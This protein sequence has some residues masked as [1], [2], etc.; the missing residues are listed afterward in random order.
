M[1]NLSEYI[2]ELEVQAT[3]SQ[4]AKDQLEALRYIVVRDFSDFIGKIDT[5]DMGNQL[6]KVLRSTKDTD[7]VPMEEATHVATVRYKRKGDRKASRFKVYG[8]SYPDAVARANRAL[9]NG[10]F[11]EGNPRCTVEGKTVTLE[12]V[13]KKAIY[14][15]TNTRVQKEKA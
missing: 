5:E 11:R 4:R 14:E 13:G 3:G 2:R 10:F 7:K 9:T 8:R 6:T 1:T 15:I 12:L